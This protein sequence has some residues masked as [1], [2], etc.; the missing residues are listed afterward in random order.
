MTT[1]FPLSASVGQT[2]NGYE[3]DGTSWNIIGIDLT[4]DYATQIELD[5]HT[6]DTTNVHGITNSASVVYT[7]DSRLS[8]ARTPTSHSFTHASAGSDPITIEQSQVT[9]LTSVL[10]SKMDYALP[11]NAQTGTTYTFVAGDAEKLTT[12]NN[13]AAVTLTIPPHS[14]VTWVNNTILRVVNY[15][16]GDVTVAGGSGVIVTNTA[17]KIQQYQS[18]A[19]IRTGVDTWTLVPFGGAGNPPLSVEYLVVAGG[20]GGGGAGS[21]WA[22]AGGGGA[23]GYRSSVT[24]EKSGGGANPESVFNV[25]L[26]TTYTITVGAGGSGGPGY[27]R[28]VNGSNSTF[29]TISATG[30]GAGGAFLSGSLSGG[31]GGGGPGYTNVSQSGS[32]GTANQGYAG[33]NGLGG[34]DVSSCGG[35]GGGA[36]STG[37]NAYPVGG[38]GNGGLG[39]GSAITGSFVQRAGGGGGGGNTRGLGNSGGG[40]GGT[41]NGNGSSATA[42]TGGGG[43][44]ACGSSSGGGTVGGNGGSGIVS[45]R[46]SIL[47]PPATSTTGSPTV[48]TTSLFRIY[49]FTGN[50]S[51][52][53]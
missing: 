2:F 17:T 22:T 20:G 43:G 21:T 14:S 27:T 49:T 45:I 25:T 5:T 32:A 29:S 37:N 31:S 8:D 42:N 46:Y 10:S 26:G 36:A 3:F 41:G 51:I 12:A 1:I 16:A 34:A 4:Q 7:D 11:V 24:G 30:G 9:N 38:G 6:S 15:G 19:A 40:N 53:W 52:T 23:G 35:G 13:S 48:T 33:G 44:G 50:G 47:Y 28:G 18:A 39:I